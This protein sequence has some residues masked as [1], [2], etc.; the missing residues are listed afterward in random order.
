[1]TPPW[2][3]RRTRRVPAVIF[4]TAA[5][6]LFPGAAVAQDATWPRELTLE[7]GRLVL[8]QSQ[9]ETFEGNVLTGR[10]AASFTATGQSEPTFGTL[11]FTSR[12]DVNREEGTALVRAISVTRARWPDVTEE[13]ER[14]WT[15]Y[16]TGVFREVEVPI[17]FERL[18]ASLQSVQ[19]ERASLQDL[20]NDPPRVIF[21]EELTEL[22]QYDGEP[23]AIPIPDTPLEHVANAPFAVIHDTRDGAY[24]LSGGQIW[25]QAGDPLG[26]W[27]PIDQ[28]PDDIGSL[29]PPDTSS[30][31]TPSPPPAIVT[32]TEPTELIVTDGAPRWAPIGEGELLYVSNTETPLIREVA[33]G[34]VFILISGRWYR[35]GSLEG[36]WTFV[37]PDQLPDSFQQIPPASDLG[38]AR[39]SVAGTEEAENAVLDAHIPQTAAI[40]RSEATLEVTYD[41]DPKFQRIDGTSVEYAVNTGAQVLRIGGRYYACDNGVWFESG[42]ASG[43]WAVADEVPSDEIA[44]IPPSE[45]VYNVTHVHVYDST[46]QV[47]YVGYT[48]GYLW[49]FPYYGVPVY[50]TGWYY[51]PY[52]GP[53]YYYPRP[54]TYGFH[55]NY[56]PWTGWSMGFSWSVGF[57]QVGFSFGGGYGGY[58]RPGWGPGWHGGYPPGG[59]R[60]PVLINTGD[61]NIG[62]RVNVG[63]RVGGERIANRDAN[64]YDQASNRGRLADRQVRERSQEKLRAD[65][66]AQG[67]ND[68]L[69]DRDGNVFRQNRNG[70]WDSRDRGEWRSAAPER[71]GGA[72]R[73]QANRQVP[74]QVQRDYGARQ[75]GA[76]RAASRPSGGR[77]GRR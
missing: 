1:M 47:V 4:M 65:R 75:R 48:P 43:P 37:R 52:W 50:G 59:Y 58:Y 77:R 21:R 29:V 22:L 14:E 5:A 46:P 19:A 36:P 27:T 51:P 31:P 2:R 33:T 45:P 39:V 53:R 54:V 42:E 3:P 25:Y 60:R 12:V 9:P 66:V 23:R 61:I 67:R 56:N 76:G 30:T 8:Y 6:T 7:R 34:Q 16:L 17:S 62:N 49:S 68:V 73:P 64:L 15:T 18:S 63:D 72:Q 44:Q 74:Q 41:G 35:G 26:P 24:Y 70:T 38:G 40:E 69:S 10:A 11:W 71:G 57:M 32:A 28:P 13:S 55:V 20:K